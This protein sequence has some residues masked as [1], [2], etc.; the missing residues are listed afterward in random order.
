[1]E[2][3]TAGREVAGCCCCHDA[4]Q[5]SHDPGW[6]TLKGTNLMLHLVAALGGG[7]QVQHEVGALEGGPAGKQ[8]LQRRAREPVRPLPG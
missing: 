7:G 4:V 1:M 2:L 8:V 5:R 3:Q 6:S